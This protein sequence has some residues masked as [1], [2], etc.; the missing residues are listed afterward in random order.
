MSSARIQRYLLLLQQGAL[1]AQKRMISIKIRKAELEESFR[2]GTK[3][4][5]CPNMGFE[6]NIKMALDLLRGLI[7]DKEYPLIFR[8]SR[9]VHSFRKSIKFRIFRQ[10]DDQTISDV[11]IIKEIL[12]KTDKLIRSYLKQI[13]IQISIIDSINDSNFHKLRIEFL[14]SYIKQQKT[15]S[16]LVSRLKQMRGLYN[17]FIVD[18]EDEL[19][20]RLKSQRNVDISTT[21]IMIVTILFLAYM[22]GILTGILDYFGF[23][24]LIR[25]LR[26]LSSGNQVSPQT[27]EVL[28]KFFMVV[29]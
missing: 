22:S 16:E 13:E 1:E 15:Y 2:M 28:K 25:L 12:K 24:D 23:N 11:E 29:R 3:V 7:K 20:K 8:I 10:A 17:K 4:R 19:R 21:F 9:G 18:A 26:D 27:E 14:D 5:G 6:G